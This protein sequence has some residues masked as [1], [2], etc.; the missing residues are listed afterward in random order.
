MVNGLVGPVA[1][2]VGCVAEEAFEDGADFGW[3]VGF[4]EGGQHELQPTIAR[5]FVDGEVGVAHAEAGMAALLDVAEGS[6]EA[7]DEEIAE[8]FF[9][10]GHVG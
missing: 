2:E 5:T 8:P 6:A 1:K 4:V 10:A 7:A 9:G 3:Q